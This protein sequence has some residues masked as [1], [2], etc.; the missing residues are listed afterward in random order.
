[1]IN[2]IIAVNALGLPE[3][4]ASG[5]KLAEILTYSFVIL[6]S[7]ALLVLVM[8]GIRFMFAA[9]N[10]EKIAKA[11]N[12]IIYALV[13]LVVAVFAATIVKFVLGRTT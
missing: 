6:G 13:G 2:K 8:A 12:T 4:D 9:G 7:I 5:A 3:P 1:M 10:P 11:R